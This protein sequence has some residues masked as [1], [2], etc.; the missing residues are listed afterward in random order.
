M[1]RFATR[2]KERVL[3]DLTQKLRDLPENHP[4]YRV[5]SRMIRDLVAEIGVGPQGILRPSS[6]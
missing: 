5:L 6:K 2:S 3:E 4:D 1:I